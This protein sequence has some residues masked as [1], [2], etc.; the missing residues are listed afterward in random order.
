LETTEAP[1]F[2]GAEQPETKVNLL[3]ITI[4]FPKEYTDGSLELRI[5]N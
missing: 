3:I 1:V 2:P 5:T 4:L